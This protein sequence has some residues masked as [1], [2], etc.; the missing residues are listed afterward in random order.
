MD[1]FLGLYVEPE[2]L[3]YF[4]PGSV[5]VV[6]DRPYTVR[7]TRRGKKGPQVAFVEIT[8]RD[9]AE[10][11]RGSDVLARERRRL[12]ENEFWP[13]DLVGLE[14]RPGGGSVVGVEHGPSQDR[15]VIERG[16]E[17]F[18]VPFVDDLVP[19]VDIPAGFVEIDEID[20]LI[21]PSDRQ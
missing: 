3:V 6:A 18:E 19:V 14:V 5:V 9:A 17:V 16:Q 1:G 7:A 20:G 21:R 10:P 4:E 12:V 15:L 8:T 11:M 13:S 2:D